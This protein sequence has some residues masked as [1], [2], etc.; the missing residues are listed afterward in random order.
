MDL[1]KKYNDLVNE[2]LGK[3]TLYNEG[4]GFT[5]NKKNSI[6]YK[7]RFNYYCGILHV[8]EEE[9]EIL[10]IKLKYDQSWIANLSWKDICI[11][12]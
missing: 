5:P 12:G 3:R 4:S 2:V 10:G 11:A 7:N 8:L 1:K 6:I 9:A